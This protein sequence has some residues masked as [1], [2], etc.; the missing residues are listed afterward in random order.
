MLAPLPFERFD[1]GLVL[2]PRVD[3]SSMVTVRQSKYSVPA[4]LIG[5]PV[6]VSL[7]REAC[8]IDGDTTDTKALIDVFF[9]H[10][11]L[12]AAD[13]VAGIR[14][15]LSVGAVSADGVAVQARLHAGGCVLSPSSR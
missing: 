11:S 6:L 3:R 5:P 4:Y 9:L 14:A 12:R 15:A 7:W 10:Q 2:H 1:P 13:I 8:K